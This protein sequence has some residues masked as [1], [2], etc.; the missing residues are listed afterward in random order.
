MTKQ[1]P[2]FITG[3]D[4]G[5]GKTVTSA[6]LTEKLKADYWK[7]IQSGD[8]DESDTLKVKSLVSNTQTVFHPETYR[9]TQPYS[10]HKSAA[11]DGI[12]IDM[13]AF[14][15]PET[16]NILIIEGAGGL[17][18]PL[19]E[20]DLMIDLIKKLQAEV[21]LISQNYL[22]SI[23]HTILSWKALQQENIPIKGIIFNGETDAE[24]ERYILQ[25]TGLK[26]LGKV[27]QL[28]TIDKQAIINACDLITAI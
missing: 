20:Y 22:G 13:N 19:N 7:P 11:I 17:M 8:L 24:S 9:L 4:T 6:V 15:I 25:Y 16:D 21:I 28:E 18:V 26:L 3:I 12:V 27:P 23:N 1:N 10:P 2:I 5:I 14:S